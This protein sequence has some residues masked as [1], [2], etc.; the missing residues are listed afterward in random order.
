MWK[1]GTIGIPR[2]DGSYKAVHYWIK[3]FEEGSQFGINGGR[4]SKLSLKMDGEWVANYDRGWDIQPTCEE[5]EMALC[6]LLYSHN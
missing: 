1:E 6:I 3:V 2:K 5:A 4:I